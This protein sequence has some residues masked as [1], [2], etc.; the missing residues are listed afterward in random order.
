MEESSNPESG[1]FHFFVI[2]DGCNTK[3]TGSVATK[4]GEISGTKNKRLEEQVSNTIGY[5]K[6]PLERQS[7]S[8]VKIT[9]SA[10]CK[11]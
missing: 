2:F 6:S 8:E 10:I 3:K 1:T 9:G 11:P 7:L 4:A 5:K